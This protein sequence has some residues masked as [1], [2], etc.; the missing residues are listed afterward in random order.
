MIKHAR[1]FTTVAVVL[2]AGASLTARAPAP[3]PASRHDVV[4]YGGTSAGVM[5][6]IQVARAG[7]SVALVEPTNWLGGLTTAGLG[8]VDAGKPAAVGGLA[9]EFYHRLWLHYKAPGA[10]T[11]SPPMALLP[12]HGATEDETTMWLHEPSVAKMIIEGM[13]AEAKV[14]VVRN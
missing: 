8:F 2:A 4:V 6:A 13:V 3:A 11:W 1:A 5:A 14:T 10:W 9:I 7:K 12:Q